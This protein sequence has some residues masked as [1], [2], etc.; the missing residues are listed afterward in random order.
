M[1]RELERNFGPGCSH[2]TCV[3]A[4]AHAF[5]SEIYVST[6]SLESIGCSL[7]PFMFYKLCIFSCSY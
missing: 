7:V 3:C 6:Q 4:H 1:S 5:N 2:L